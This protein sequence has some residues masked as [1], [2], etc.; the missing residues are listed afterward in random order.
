MITICTFSEGP[1]YYAIDWKFIA[2]CKSEVFNVSLQR[3]TV[4]LVAGVIFTASIALLFLNF[5]L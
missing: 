4:S 5:L 2:A 3:T 1:F